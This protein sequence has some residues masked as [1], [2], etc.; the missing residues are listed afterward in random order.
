MGPRYPEAPQSTRAQGGP[1]QGQS[2]H[3]PRKGLKSVPDGGHLAATVQKTQGA[4][5]TS[6]QA[7]PAAG[8][9]RADRAPGPKTRGHRRRPNRARGTRGFFSS[10]ISLF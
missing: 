3:L 4:A 10:N 1:P 6:L 9:A 8:Y 2:C 7:P 5:T